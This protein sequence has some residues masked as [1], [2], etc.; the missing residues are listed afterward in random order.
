VCVCVRVHTH[1]QNA[2][3]GGKSLCSACT[4]LLISGIEACPREERTEDGNLFR[5]ER[6][7]AIGKEREGER[8]REREIRMGENNVGVNSIN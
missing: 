6:E 1:T 4:I 7:M 8:E 3:T 5:G 2:P